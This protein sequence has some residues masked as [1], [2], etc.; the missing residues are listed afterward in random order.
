MYSD[1]LK[2]SKSRY[3]DISSEKEE[4]SKDTSDLQERIDEQK[5]SFFARKKLEQSMKEEIVSEVEEVQDKTEDIEE[6][7]SFMDKVKAVNWKFW[8][9]VQSEDEDSED[10]EDDA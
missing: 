9:K 7:E 2:T 5:L 3:S 8:E 10:K 1:I 4:G 6:K